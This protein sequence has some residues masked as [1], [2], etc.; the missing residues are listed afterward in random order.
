MNW[1][2]FR[3]WNI[4]CV[5]YPA[6]ILR[7]RHVGISEVSGAPAMNRITHKLRRGDKHGKQN[8]QADSVDMTKAVYGIVASTSKI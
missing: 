6:V 2:G 5:S 7:V 8:E 1:Y 4:V 3:H